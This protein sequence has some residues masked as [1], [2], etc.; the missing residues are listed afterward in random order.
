MR[1]RPGG[2]EAGA[3]FEVQRASGAEFYESSSG[4][5]WTRGF[6]DPAAEYWAVRRKAGLW[7]VSSLAKFHLVGR[8]VL[9]ALDRLTTRAM[10]GVEAGTV[11]YLMIL[12]ERGLMLDEGTAL[13]LSAQEAYLLGNDASDRFLAHLVEHTADLDVRIENVTELISNISVQ[14]P[15][16]LEILSALTDVD[17]A[18]LRWFGLMPEPV[19]LAGVRG[20]LVRA[21]YTGERG[22][23]FYLL[24]GNGGAER[25]WEAIV[26]A[27]AAP[28][29]FDAIDMLRV[30]A[31]LV[32]ARREYWSGVTSPYD[33]SF[34]RFVELDHAF[35]GR[36]ACAAVAQAPPSRLVTLTFDGLELPDRGSEVR[37]VDGSVGTVTS[38][39]I[40]PACGP[41]ALA[42]VSS[43]RSREGTRLSAG[44]RPATVRPL[45]IYDPEKQRSRG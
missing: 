22:Y 24:D 26:E 20:I 14:G 15:G 33:L 29:G 23:E 34:D 45:P 39:V 28:I 10:L 32:M 5:L 3:F 31:G 19:E 35:I 4:R 1:I 37:D 27:G 16:S 9:P 7:D 30:E 44:G 43:E 41:L 17:I 2:A 6:G 42:V 18:A 8:D 12:N 38:A 25:L 40:T 11:R 36:D 21:G 13:V